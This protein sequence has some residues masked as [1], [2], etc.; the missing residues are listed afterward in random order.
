M[1]R[2]WIQLSGPHNW[3]CFFF[4]LPQIYIYNG[5]TLTQSE[6]LNTTQKTDD[7][8]GQERDYGSFVYACICGLSDHPEVQPTD[9]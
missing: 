6:S 5:Q 7:K 9:S 2:L 3:Q 1:L 8:I 4:P